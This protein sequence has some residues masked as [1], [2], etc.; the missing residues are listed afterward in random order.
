MAAIVSFLAPL[1][2]EG[3]G[4]LRILRTLRFLRSYQLLARLRADSA[5]FRRNEDV[6][7]A[8]GQSG[9]VHLRHDRL[10]L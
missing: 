7:I 9:R 6:I 10:R 8:I 1:I 3:A 5:Y 2:G 4:F